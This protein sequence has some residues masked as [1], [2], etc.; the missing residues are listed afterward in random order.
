LAHRLT[1]CGVRYFFF[2]G[3]VAALA[4]DHVNSSWDLLGELALGIFSAADAGSLFHTHFTTNIWMCYVSLLIFKSSYM[5]LIT[6]AASVCIIS[7]F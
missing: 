6:I 2:S 7:F 5:L 1:R 3:A 4:V